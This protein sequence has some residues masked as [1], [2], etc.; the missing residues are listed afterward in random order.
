MLSHAL[1][2]YYEPL[3]LPLQSTA[4]SFPYTRQLMFLGHH[5]NGS[6]ALDCLSSKTCRP[7]YPGRSY[8]PFPLSEPVHIGLPRLSTGSA[9]SRNFTRLHPGSLA[10]RPA[11]LPIGN[12]RPS[13]TRTPLPW[14]TGANRT[15][16]RT[17][18]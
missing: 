10:L 16:P 3:R 17:G 2:R 6:P 18:L 14:A 8:W 7:F 13:V 9:S 15:I 11:S 12:L 1:K 4:I 5:H